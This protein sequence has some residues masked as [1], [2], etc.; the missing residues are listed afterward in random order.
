MAYNV[1]Y[2]LTIESVVINTCKWLVERVALSCY[3][4]MNRITLCFLRLVLFGLLTQML[5][6]RKRNHISVSIAS[7]ES[8]INH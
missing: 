7:G 8:Q 5:H 1:F 2:L 4:R 6:T 3:S